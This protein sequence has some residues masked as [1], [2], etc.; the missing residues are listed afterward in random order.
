MKLADAYR[1]RAEPRSRVWQS[2][3]LPWA[4]VVQRPMAQ[5]PH[6]T[7]QSRAAETKPTAPSSRFEKFLY[8]PCSTRYNRLCMSIYD[9][10][11]AAAFK[12]LAKP[13]PSTA[14]QQKSRKI[15]DDVQARIP[16]PAFRQALDSSFQA[17]AAFSDQTK[18]QTARE[19]LSLLQALNARALPATAEILFSTA[20]DALKDLDAESLLQP[21]PTP[22][23]VEL[24]LKASGTPKKVLQERLLANPE[25][26]YATAGCDWFFRKGDTRNAAPLLLHLLSQE[27]RPEHLPS[28]EEVLTLALQRDKKGI[29]METVL[30]QH[31]NHQQAI[32]SLVTVALKDRFLLKATMDVLPTLFSRK[33]F[34]GQP[35]EF[36]RRLLDQAVAT[37]ADSRRSGSANIARLATGILLEGRL[38]GPAQEAL[39]AIQTATRR[40]RRMTFDATL[41]ADT[42]LIE[43][44]GD[45]S[46]DEPD[47]QV[48]ITRKGA[49]HLAIAFEKA[50]QGF[51]AYEIL[52][53]TARNLGMAPTGK[54]GDK[55]A[56]NPLNHADLKGGI[57]PGETVVVVEPG[58]LLKDEMVIR[59]KVIRPGAP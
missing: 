54:M 45:V 36:L 4:A 5:C 16:D 44:L 59:A 13:S 27:R 12:A 19:Y 2:R 30:L 6:E 15:L 58:W 55:V 35:V 23:C 53:V 11:L 24:W 34:S 28:W 29:L 25:W 14:D 48:H 32:P 18:R 52:A 56:Y 9:R 31:P 39:E 41:K 8:L 38:S 37:Q 3:S 42:W 46:Q 49:R 47:G 21:A 40:L 20:L 10:R 22:K 51:G 50:S 57:I 33:T 43:C 17:V 26:A 7:Q 1:S